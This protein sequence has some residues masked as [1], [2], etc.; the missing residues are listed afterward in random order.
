M[1]D[2]G[3]MICLPASAP[4]WRNERCTFLDPRVYGSVRL[5][6]NHECCT[7]DTGPQVKKRRRL[8]IEVSSSDD[9]DLELPAE[10]VDPAKTVEPVEPA[11]SECSESD[12]ELSSGSE[13]EHDEEQPVVPDVIRGLGFACVD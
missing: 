4:L 5:R 10:T 13:D 3:G 8:R 12:I 2:A 11:H 1:A 9:E 7:A 6:C